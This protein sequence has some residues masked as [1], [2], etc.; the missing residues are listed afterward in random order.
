[1]PDIAVDTGTCKYT[2]VSTAMCLCG[3]SLLRFYGSLY[4]QAFVSLCFADFVSERSPSN[5]RP[6]LLEAYA[7]T[8]FKLLSPCSRVPGE[9]RGWPYYLRRCGN[10]DGHRADRT[11]RRPI[12]GTNRG[13]RI[14]TMPVQLIISWGMLTRLRKVLEVD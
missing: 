11:Q 2:T 5:F 6:D 8:S 4:L 3:F 1:M 7:S 9:T 13:G 12:A 14:E 10:R